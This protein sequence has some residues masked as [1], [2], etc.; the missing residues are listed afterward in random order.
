M[1][2]YFGIIIVATIFALNPILKKHM[3]NDFTGDEVQVYSTIIAL[4]IIFI[5]SRFNDNGCLQLKELKT[6]KWYNYLLLLIASCL[7]VIYSMFLN[8]LLKDNR[9]DTVMGH[10]RCIELIALFL[11]ASLF[12]GSFTYK[13]LIGI[14]VVVIGIY[15]SK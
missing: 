2:Y 4:I 12:F 8:S 3:L 15:I 10:I 9:P 13:K 7:V 14:I 5:V 11:L 6:H 1:N